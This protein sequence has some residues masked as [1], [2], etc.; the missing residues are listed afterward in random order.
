MVQKALTPRALAWMEP[1]IADVAEELARAL[2]DGPA[3]GFIDAFA[4]PLPV[5]AISRVLGLPDD[6]RA[7]V[8]RWTDAATATIG[9][10]LAPERWAQ[11]ERDLLDYQLSIAAELEQ[12]RQAPRDDLLS[13]LVAAAADPG[14]GQEPIGIAELVSLTRELMVAGNESTL[15]L[16][17]DI[18]WQLD[19]SPQ[20][21]DLVRADE[22]RAHK[23][24]EEAVRMAS[25]SAAVFRRVAQDTMLGGVPL[26]AGSTLVVS[27]LSANRDESVFSDG[28]RFD[29]D[30]PPVQRHIAFGQGI[31]ACIGNI[32]AR[33]EARHAVRALA[34]HV[35]RIDVIRDEP[36]R[37]LPSLIVR[38]LVELPVQVRRRPHVLPF[39]RRSQVLA[40]GQHEPPGQ[41]EHIGRG[42]RGPGDQVQHHQGQG[43]SDG[44]ADQQAQRA[45]AANP[46]RDLGRSDQQPPRRHRR[47]PGVGGHRR[48]RRG[49]RSGLLHEVGV[50]LAAG[51]RGAQLGVGGRRGRV[52]GQVAAVGPVGV[53]GGGDRPPGRADLLVAQV[54]PGRQPEGR[55]RVGV[56][57]GPPGPKTSSRLAGPC[58]QAGGRGSGSRRGS[59]TWTTGSP[60]R[61]GSSVR[62]D[63]LGR[64]TCTNVASPPWM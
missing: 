62:G 27:L 58:G 11:V 42:R 39:R 13:M 64:A 6:R 20:E 29:P 3:I 52:P 25:P 18:I 47:R 22:A 31:H 32:L 55:E 46:R 5:W 34:G 17:A 38:G 28:D 33:M 51:P 59:G 12:R 61:A 35:N 9:A 21:W 7:D 30:R 56:H 14:S 37:Y 53:G 60:A 63:A 50:G 8:R 41:A 57:R 49:V 15:R 1:L 44:T 16:L 24:V 36:L 19:S 45:A 10:Q 48:Q 4:R 2:P 26:L 40:P 43:R 23:I 54:G